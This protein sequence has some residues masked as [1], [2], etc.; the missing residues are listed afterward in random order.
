MFWN[1][2]EVFL[3]SV[4]V[5]TRDM[6]FRE[7]DVHFIEEKTVPYVLTHGYR[8]RSDKHRFPICLQR[9]R[10]KPDVYLYKYTYY[11]N[12]LMITLMLCH[13]NALIS[14]DPQL[15]YDTPTD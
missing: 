11:I 7:Y 10:Y 3:N 5:F 8:V 9:K 15:G 12:P 14:I 6:Y 4:Y 1:P 2:T 13:F